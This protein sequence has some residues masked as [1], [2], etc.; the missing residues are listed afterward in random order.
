MQ[1]LLRLEKFS[2]F[3]KKYDNDRIPLGL[4]ARRT[5]REE[6]FM[7]NLLRLIWA[8]IHSGGDHRERNSVENAHRTEK[9]SAGGRELP[10]SE[11][12]KET[13]ESAGE[14]RG[15]TGAEIRDRAPG[16]L[17]LGR[18]TAESRGETGAEIRDR[19]PGGQSRAEDT[20]QA[21][22][23]PEGSD[24]PDDT[25]EWERIPEEVEREDFLLSQIDE[26]REKAK[27]LQELIAAKETK[28]QELQSI[29]SERED[30]AQ[31]LETILTERQEEADRIVSEFTRV[32]D[33]LSGQVT[34]KM[35]EIERSISGQ[36]EQ[37]KQTSEEAFAAG[38]S[39]N[40]E[41]F[42]VSRK[43]NEEQMAA[44]QKL[45]EEQISANRMFLEEQAA[46][47]RRIGDAQIKEVRELLENTTTQ[48]TTIK[49]ELSEKVHSENVKCYRNIQDLFGEF[50]TKI[51]KMDELEQ[52]VGSVKSYAKSLA[53]FTILNFIILI[54]VLLCTVGVIHI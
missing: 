45:S 42:A 18:T 31:E 20:G 10:T 1:R 28:A 51:E 25:K 3:T 36:V 16:G 2:S 34:S 15:E 46:A 5:Q 33:S 27:Q 11:N 49:A 48:L 41:Q 21:Q 26:F 53:V 37:L 9:T 52:G 47:S 6:A 17:S 4:F 44:S 19:V 50:D 39:L 29:V 40:E 35:A 22:E 32:V 8:Q 54:V 38:R 43:L 30:K 24:M 7:A 14:S 23:R 13:E 12:R